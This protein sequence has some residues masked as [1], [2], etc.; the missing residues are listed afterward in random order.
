MGC[1]HGSP[2]HR[3][4]GP[5]LADAVATDDVS[6]ERGFAASKGHAGFGGGKF[7]GQ[8]GDDA[9]VSTDGERRRG[10]SLESSDHATSKSTF[11]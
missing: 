3:L 1:F 4:Q 9:A 10:G 6:A 2:R 8:S 7:C 5:A 11:G